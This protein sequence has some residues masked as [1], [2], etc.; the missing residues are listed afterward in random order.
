MVLDVLGVLPLHPLGCPTECTCCLG[1]D[2]LDLGTYGCLGGPTVCLDPGYQGP[3]DVTPGGGGRGGEDTD[4][5]AGLCSL[6]G[7]AHSYLLTLLGIDG[8]YLVIMHNV[9]LLSVTTVTTTDY[10]LNL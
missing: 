2:G 5:P 9:L 1:P 8:M 6:E 7:V 10:R 4:S 3:T